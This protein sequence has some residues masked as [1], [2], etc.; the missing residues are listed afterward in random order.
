L[1]SDQFDESQLADFSVAA[2][3]LEREGHRNGSCTFRFRQR[4]N[5]EEHV[6]SCDA[7]DKVEPKGDKMGSTKE[8][9]SLHFNGEIESGV[10][11]QN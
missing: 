4:M 9:V 11:N 6:N 7:L 3:I 10:L 1:F 8:S 2:D 5:N